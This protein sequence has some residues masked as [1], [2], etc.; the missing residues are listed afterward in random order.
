MPDF[1]RGPAETSSPWPPSDER[2][3]ATDIVLAELV[4]APPR[5][6]GPP[7]LRERRWTIPVILFL[8]TCWTT[9]QVGTQSESPHSWESVIAGLSY[10]V[11]VMTILL[12]H[13]LGHFLQTLR[14][15]VRA[16][17]P[18]F[19]PIPFASITGTLGAVIGMEPHMSHRRALF[20][21]GISGP[22]LGLIPTLVCC[23]V[24]LY[25]SE[26]KDLAAVPTGIPLGDPLLFH[27]LAQAIHGP[28]PPGHEIFLHP[29]G[30]A[31]WVG[32]LVTSLNLFP[33]GQ[34]DGGHIL[35]ALLRRKAHLVAT[36]ILAG[37]VVGVAYF[38]LYGWIIMLVLIVLMGPKHPPTAND[39]APL[40]W[41]RS[42][43]GW[44]TLAFLP[45][46]FT[47]MPIQFTP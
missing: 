38:R 28:V 1:E 25:L 39:D 13:E 16:T 18:I 22:L 35:Y 23:V 10:C 36:L 43:L 34:L 32:L 17:L 24:G 45:F 20:D 27:F 14:Y 33:I 40:G 12:C 5:K 44:V 47:P 2:A 4:A 46:G 11:P 42:V 6:E 19:I 7:P 9:Y 31:G 30:Y 3:E 8:A 29:V 41:G 21:I 15:G 37:A 26:V